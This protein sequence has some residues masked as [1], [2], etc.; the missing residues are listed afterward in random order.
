M[1]DIASPIIEGFDLLVTFSYNLNFVLGLEVNHTDIYNNYVSNFNI[2][3]CHK[4]FI[5]N[6]FTGWRYHPF[7]I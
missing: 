4:A 2:L 1:N 3:F 5:L 6:N 7:Y